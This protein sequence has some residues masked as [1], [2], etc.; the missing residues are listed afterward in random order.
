MHL[1]DLIKDSLDVID[2]LCHTSTSYAN[3][4]QEVI[5]QL[6]FNQIN[7]YKKGQVNKYVK[8]FKKQFISFN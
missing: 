6:E 7:N 3:I 1:R 8:I 2:V 4:S 5:Y